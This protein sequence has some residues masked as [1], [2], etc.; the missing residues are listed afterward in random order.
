[1]R[2]LSTTLR[3]LVALFVDDGGVALLTLSWLAV[4]WL[5]LPW[6]IP[7]HGWRGLLLF[8][9][10]A[11]IVVGSVLRRSRPSSQRK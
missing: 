5:L 11:A 7:Q 9:G 10:L 2:W 8:L 6:L 4:A 3:Q 1:M